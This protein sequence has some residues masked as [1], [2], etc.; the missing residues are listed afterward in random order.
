[1]DQILK[2]NAVNFNILATIPFLLLTYGII[3]F[4]NKWILR[5]TWSSKKVVAKVQRSKRILSELEQLY[6]L[7]MPNMP[8]AQQTTSTTSA[9]SIAHSPRDRRP[10]L[11]AAFQTL[12]ITELASLGSQEQEEEDEALR[13]QAPSTAFIQPGTEI[14]GILDHATETAEPI[15]DEEG[16]EEETTPHATQSSESAPSH[17]LHATSSHSTARALFANQSV[18][19]TSPRSPS[20]LGLNNHAYGHSLLL[21]HEL[22][23]QLST[24]PLASAFGSAQLTSSGGATDPRA[25]LHRDCILLASDQLSPAQKLQWVLHMQRAY[26]F[27]A[28]P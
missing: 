3:D 4:S 1:M 23:R 28:A 9:P 14:F 18:P 27:L 10:R 16:D 2:S 5:G 7:H 20:V 17:S 13:L 8:M 25:I 26:A 22:S 21:L 24:L 15:S 11:H 6:I 19:G 12:N